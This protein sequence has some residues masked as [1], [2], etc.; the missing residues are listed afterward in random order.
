MECCKQMVVRA[1]LIGTMG[2]LS[3]SSR[4]FRATLHRSLSSGLS[5]GQEKK[6]SD[7]S[8]FYSMYYYLVM[9]KGIQTPL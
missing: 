2:A 4:G 9:R 1:S 6:E 3:V 5:H 7:E 8:G